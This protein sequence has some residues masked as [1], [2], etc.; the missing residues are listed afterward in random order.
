MRSDQLRRMSFLPVLT[1]LALVLFTGWVDAQTPRR[2]A[3]PL[4]TPPPVLTG[5][6]IISRGGTEPDASEPDAEPLATPVPDQGA[7]VTELR[8][9]IKKLESER[10]LTYDEKQKRMMLNLD[11]LTRAEQR[12]ESLRKQLFEMIEKENTVK[13]RLDQIEFDMRPEI[14]ERALQI[15]GSLRPEEIRQSRR[16]SLEAERTNLQTLLSEVQNNRNN[17]NNNLLKADQMVERLRSKLEK[18]IDD[19]FLTDEETR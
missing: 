1:L 5:A 3:K 16:R 8:N 13:S 12:T 11:I 14:I 6:E 7:D 18:D 17:L 2:K 9:K 15:A 10:K 4:A 19:S